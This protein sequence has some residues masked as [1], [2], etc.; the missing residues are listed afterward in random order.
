MLA[1]RSTIE[2]F[3][4]YLRID[5][6]TMGQMVVSVA[7]VVVLLLVRAILVHVIGRR[8]GDVMRHYHWRRG[9]NYSTGLL[10]VLLVGAVWVEALVQL[11]VVLGVAAAGLTIAMKEPLLN[12]A[13]WIHILIYRPFDVGDRIEVNGVTGDVI[14]IRPFQTY[15][16][17]C[18]RWVEVDQSTGRRM[19]IP[20]M[21]VFTHPLA[22]YTRGFEFIW[23]EVNV[24]VTFESDWRLAKRLLQD[25]GQSHARAFCEGAQ[26]QLRRAAREHMIFFQKL[27]PVVHVKVV[28]S[29]VQLTLR[30]LAPVRRRRLCMQEVW[31]AILDAFAGQADIAFAYSTSR[32]YEGPVGAP[33][34]QGPAPI[35]ARDAAGAD[36]DAG[37]W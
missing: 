31:E 3:A 15:L 24:R 16:L 28:E 19:L 10:A 5:R 36:A 9:V 30:Y 27:T 34:E 37:R 6:A 8:I 33:G 14:D 35:P 17:E 1:T 25:V 11:T 12:L 2:Q 20:N 21:L 13:G 32:L 4:D 22:N 23:D 29:G 26:H 7:I 18:G